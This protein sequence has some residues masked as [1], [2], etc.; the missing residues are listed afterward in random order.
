M[1]NLEQQ[2]Q[3]FKNFKSAFVIKNFADNIY[4]NQSLK[5]RIRKSDKRFPELDVWT[6]QPKRAIKTQH[7]L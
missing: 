6:S 4:F 7:H 1:E 3:K 5:Q 2:E